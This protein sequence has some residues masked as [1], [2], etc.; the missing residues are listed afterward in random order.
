MPPL[1]I[2]FLSMILFSI[3]F[4]THAW[5]VM[6]LAMLY[7]TSWIFWF[8]V[9]PDAVPHLSYSHTIAGALAWSVI[10]SFYNAFFLIRDLDLI[11]RTYFY[12]VLAMCDVSVTVC[13]LMMVCNT[14]RDKGIFWSSNMLELAS[15]G[16]ISAQAVRGGV[17]SSAVPI[18]V[19]IAL[20]RFVQDGVYKEL[21]VWVVCAVLEGAVQDDL[22]LYASLCGVLSIVFVYVYR[23]NALLVLLSPII[24]FATACKLLWRRRKSKW[25][26]VIQRTKMDGLDIYMKLSNYFL[27]LPTRA[28]DSAPPEATR[29]W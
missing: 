6:P 26:A 9:F 19:S 27:P 28:D 25:P 16:W 4:L 10:Y 23:H 12:I 20:I 22:V 2:F 5:W 21:F 8:A 24:A 29:W 14:L 3:Y 13:V 15:L 11:P 7:Q 1:F 17:L 18:L